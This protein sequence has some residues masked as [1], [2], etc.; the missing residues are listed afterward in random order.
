MRR[1]AGVFPGQDPAL[2]G[3][4]LLK[5]IDVFEVQCVNC[6]IDLGLRP[7]RPHFDQA[8]AATGAGLFNVRL[9]GHTCLLN[10]AM[11]CMTP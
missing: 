1:Q 10:L 7:L 11:N 9:A 5:Q 6:E 2:L 8:D 4:K 3:Y